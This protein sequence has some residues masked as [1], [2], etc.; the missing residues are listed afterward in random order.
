MTDFLDRVLSD[1]ASEHRDD[2]SLSDCTLKALAQRDDSDEVIR[3]LLSAFEREINGGYT[4]HTQQACL[5]RALQ[6]IAAHGNAEPAERRV[7]QSGAPGE[8][9]TP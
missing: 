7:A 2:C 1:H 8:Q 9:V 5:W 4:T 6:V 3:D